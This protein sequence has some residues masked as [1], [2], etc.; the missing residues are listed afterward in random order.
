MHSVTTS[1]HNSLSVEAKNIILIHHLRRCQL[2]RHEYR[3][4][5]K[6]IEKWSNITAWKQ[7][8]IRIKPYL[9][10]TESNKY[11]ILSG[12]GL[13]P[14]LHRSLPVFMLTTRADSLSLSPK[15][16]VI[17]TVQFHFR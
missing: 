6:G 10:A 14:F 4:E 15:R 16:R 13:I 17:L 9:S 5:I 8:S 1:V 12:L 7:E 3:K 11:P 2:S